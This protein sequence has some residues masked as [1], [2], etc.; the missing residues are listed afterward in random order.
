MSTGNLVEGPGYF[1]WE[2]T[3]S[4]DERFTPDTAVSGDITVNNN[5]E[6]TLKM[7]GSLLQTEYPRG[8]PFFTEE[9]DFSDRV[10][11]GRLIDSRQ[12]IHLSGLRLEESYED[13]GRIMS[14][15]YRADLCLVGQNFT[16]KVRLP[17]R[18]SSQFID[19]QG[20]EQWK[21]GDALEVSLID[22]L[23]NH[24][25][26]E[27]KYTTSEDKYDLADGTLVVRSIVCRNPPFTLLPKCR[28]VDFQQ[29]DS[30]EYLPCKPPQRCETCSKA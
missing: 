2:G 25:T 26:Q 27:V 19:L 6:A 24:H 30:I 10:I 17:L 20:W 23:E 22:V 7:H 16:S 8:L 18:F 3:E 15:E 9:I 5:G 21:G 11:T 1:W 4:S 29:D 28:H 12:R 14:E 13:H